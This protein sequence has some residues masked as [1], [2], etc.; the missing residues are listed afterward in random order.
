M[1]LTLLLLIAIALL[2]TTLVKLKKVEELMKG[3][4]ELDAKLA[5]LK[6]ASD[7][8]HEEVMTALQELKDTISQGID[9]TAQIAAV[10]AAIVSIQGIYTPEVPPTL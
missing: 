1:M 3:I 5:E 6:V 10:D 8:E 7:Q 9:L 2:I 4:P